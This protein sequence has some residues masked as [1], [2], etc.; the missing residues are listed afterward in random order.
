MCIYSVEIPISNKKIPK[1]NSF[2]LKTKKKSGCQK[3]SVKIGTFRAISQK[4][5]VRKISELSRKLLLGPFSTS[6]KVKWSASFE[7]RI[8]KKGHME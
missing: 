1:K 4:V 7:V 6:V 5:A 2:G 3:Y 8:V